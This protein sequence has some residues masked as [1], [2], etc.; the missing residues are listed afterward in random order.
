M[1]YG[2]IWRGAW[3]GLVSQLFRLTSVSPGDFQTV[4]P[5]GIA[6]CQLYSECFTQTK[7]YQ[8]PVPDSVLQAREHQA[9]FQVN[10]LK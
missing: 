7:S 6:N 3:L 8:S 10:V 2:E 4:G 5:V 1:A 9:F